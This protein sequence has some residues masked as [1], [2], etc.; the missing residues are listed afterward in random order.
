MALAQYDRTGK[1]WF[2]GDGF[3][4]DDHADEFKRADGRPLECSSKMFVYNPQKR[5][6]KVRAIF[7]HV[8]R[9]PT[10][11]EFVVAGEKTKTIELSTLSEVPHNQSFWMAVR[12]NVPIFAQACHEDYTFW[13]EV[14]DALLSVRPYPGPLGNE[15]RWV[16]P[17]CYQ[18]TGKSWYERERLTILN[19]GAKA[20]KVHV[21]YLLR[22]RD[23]GG[24]EEVEIPARRV[25]ALKVW[26]RRP[27]LLGREN[28]PTVRVEGDYA[29]RI[30]ADG[31][32]IP[33]TTRRARWLGRPSVI[34]ARN[35]IGIPLAGRGHRTW[36]YPAG[37][38]RDV[39]TLPRATA[40]VQCDKTWNL[41]FV[42]N[43]DEA[44]KVKAKITFHRPDGQSLTSGALPIEPG[45]SINNRLHR[46]G[47]LGKYTRVN[48]PYAVTVTAERPVAAEV[49]SA[50]FEMWSRVM[51][52][53]MSAVNLYPG[54]L[55]DETRWWLGIGRAG[56]SDRIQAEWR[57]SYHLFNPGKKPVAVTLS[58]LGLGRK[59]EEKVEVPAGGV[60]VVE[61]TDVKGVPTGRT[62]AV[63]ADGDGPFCGQ[64]WVRTKSRGVLQTR[65]MY[66]MMGVPM[67]L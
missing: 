3:I 6:A 44:R 58:F 38:I 16:F 47:W 53:A 19:P 42:N 20:V 30:D 43:I 13:D 5:Q 67:R 14:P 15:R 21:R 39:G 2:L 49:T 24:E 61:A 46:E 36:Y 45:K 7:Y 12:S 66:S 11:I 4:W 64:A 54:P 27:V 29:V 62:F 60:R 25:A 50:E 57:Q 63:R 51:P 33:V 31:A 17:D 26:E 23:L 34:G 41:L 35:T 59:V 55:G 37:S 48:E 40:D 65:G 22:R 18:G 1:E 52:G 32:V 10:S 28:G 8:D 56:G 9:Q